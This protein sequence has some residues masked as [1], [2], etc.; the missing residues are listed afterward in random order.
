MEWSNYLAR[1]VPP[2]RKIL[3]G[4]NWKCNGTMSEVKKIVQVLN[5]GGTFP[6]S[7]EV[8]FFCLILFFLYF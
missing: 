3:I 5:E 6:L 1:G 2:T 8:L 7:S 4:G